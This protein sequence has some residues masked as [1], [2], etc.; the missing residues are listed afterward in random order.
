MPQ[1]FPLIRRL[2]PWFAALLML[3]GLT[4]AHA[5][6]LPPAGPTHIRAALAA[7]RAGHPGET[8]TLALVMQPA[9]D[10]HGY[11]SNPGD[12]GLPPTLDWTLPK[13]ASAGAMQFPVPQTLLIAGL[14]NHVYAHD[15]AI[16]IP[17][18]LPRD[19]QPGA[20][21][22]I[23][24]KAQ[25]LA[26]SATICVPEDA[27]LSTTV[28][29][30]PPSVAT[31]VD[32]RFADWRAALPAPLDQPAH[33][34]A[35]A[36][37]YR[38]A[39][40]FPA[41]ATITAP[42]VFLGTDGVIDY[43]APQAFS[44]NGD[45]LVIDLARAKTPSGQNPNGLPGV[46]SLGTD[47]KGH[48][49]GG[50]SFAAQPGAVPAPGTP[51]GGATKVPA[52]SWALLGWA[53]IG[54]LAGG[55]VLNVMPCVFPILSLKA[56][57][58]ARGNS[59]HAHL[60]A[61]AYTAGVMLACLALGG[62]MLAL[63]AAGGEVGWAFQLQDPGVVAVLLL[64]AV[65]ITLNFAG[66]YELPG[67]SLSG[68]APG[69]GGL[70]GAF[71]TG[72]LAAFVATPCT[73]PF[74]AA[75][76][77]AALVLPTLAA[78]AV[79]GALGLGLALP[80]LAIGFIPPLRRV[81]PRPGAWMVW[82]RRAMAVPM[83]LT[84]L[85]LVWLAWRLGGSAYTFAALALSGALLMLLA[86]IGGAQTKGRRAATWAVPAS[87]V[88]VLLAAGGAPRLAR[89]ERHDD[90]SLIGATPF[91]EGA[92]AAA[93]AAH[94]PV[95]A[96]FTADWCLT[97]KVNENVAIETAATADAFRKA[98][99]VVLV[100]DW[101]RRDP[102]I[103][104]FLGSVGAAGVPLYLWYPAD[105]DAQKLPQVLTTSALTALTTTG[106]HPQ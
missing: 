14:M 18:T 82:F 98:G 6:S 46:L 68:G 65:A 75:A 52:F 3:A 72:L 60:E 78:L 59:H 43:A 33:F 93:R 38:L 102:A 45:T 54:A 8:I 50:I 23:S 49:L 73:G 27:V 31:P 91:S 21:L 74:M 69:K 95:F 63:R 22:P 42:H 90:A 17:F 40:P 51:I 53:V 100:G 62:V 7:E 24:A 13:G 10:W 37:G 34:A 83:A 101:T 84:V 77:G 92:L 4:P 16:L 67:L 55:L 99:V 30:A 97:C 1:L 64:L 106:R 41:S 15:F 88:L 11:W 5:D 20:T 89:A 86:L 47:A 56:L 94:R 9:R 85:A 96:Y 71:G 48:D 57:A 87:I 39:I 80:F 79:F 12:A 44:R 104:R 58:L 26:C 105:G 25:W 81:L 32:P 61:L 70:W 66:L 76:M 36:T 35:T 19:A 2:A 28:T 103:S 29:V